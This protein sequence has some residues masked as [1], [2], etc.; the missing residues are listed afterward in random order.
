[1]KFEKN[2]I[3]ALTLLN[4]VLE[5]STRNPDETT[6]N[7]KSQKKIP[8]NLQRL[9]RIEILYKLF[10]PESYNAKKVGVNINN[11]I[12][13]DFI[14]KRATENYA[15]LYRNI[16][17]FMDEISFK[18]FSKENKEPMRFPYLKEYYCSLIEYKKC[19]NNLLSF[20]DGVYEISYP[21]YFSY[22]LVRKINKSIDQSELNYFLSYMIDP[23][24]KVFT[25][26]ELVNE[27][28]YPNEEIFDE[29]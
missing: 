8:V 1:M 12:S 17:P 18:Y 15:T 23:T 20:N 2:E 19:L 21:Y 4:L 26:E 13:G 28:N 11:I 25:L 10:L 16:V 27:Y 24:S 9:K 3:T 29:I 7:Y 5:F 6:W 14:R 22:A